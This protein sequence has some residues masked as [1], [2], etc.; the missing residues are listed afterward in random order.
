MRLAIISDIHGNWQ[1]FQAVLEDFERVNNTNDDIDLVWHLG[2][3]AAFGTHP[4]EVIR[5]VREQQDR[6]GKDVVK[7][8]GGNTDRYLVTGERFK[9]P[10]APDEETFQHLYRERIAADAVLNWNLNQLEW[11]DYDW[12]AG[13]LDKEAGAYIADYGHVIGYHAVPGD[14]E[15]ML[16]PDTPDEEAADFLLDREG[17]LAVGGHIHHQM[18]RIIGEWRVIN[19]GSVG[20]SFQSPG[21]AQW[22]VY[23]FNK[24]N[25]TVDLRE[26]PYDTQAAIRDLRETTYPEPDW[27][28]RRLGLKA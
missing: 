19:V 8:I 7:A 26:V 5:A 3:Y 15:A 11:E 1:A 27:A 14:D 12:L 4:K 9:L 28:I 2:D 24:G 22:G 20:M 17:K 16:R 10:P 6:L 23:T 25:L 21:K 18:D 13:T